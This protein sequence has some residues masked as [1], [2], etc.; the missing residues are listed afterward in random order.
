MK[1]LA[2]IITCAFLVA[3]CNN[4]KDNEFL[5]SGSAKGMENG[6]KV[7]IEVQTETGSLAKDTAIIKD[8]KF[9]LKGIIEGIDLGFI[10]IE[11]EQINLPLILEEGKIEINLVKDSLQKTSLGGTPNNE[12]FQK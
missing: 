10:R 6:K 2:F 12:K 5:I 11:N 9:E 7:F 1:K 4:L 8:G 3:S